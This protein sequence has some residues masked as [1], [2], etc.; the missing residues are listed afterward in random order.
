[1]PPADVAAHRIA[2]H[3]GDTREHLIHRDHT[4][5]VEYDPGS[6]IAF[7]DD[8]YRLVQVHFHTPSEHL[9]AHERYP[10]ELHLVH[11]S[12]EGQ[13]LVLGIL[14]QVGEPNAFLSRT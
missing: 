11:R 3:Y 8:H 14:F 6:E 2:I 9:V 13:L 12:E 7:D 4:I 10:V 1:M 5:E